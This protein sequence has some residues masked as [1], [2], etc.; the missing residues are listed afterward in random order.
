MKFS[1]EFLIKVRLKVKN[2]HRS[3]FSSLSNWKE[4]AWKKPRASTGFKPVTSAIPVRCSTNWT[5]VWSHTLGARSIYWVHISHEEWN[6]VKYIWNNS[7][8][9]YFTSFQWL[10]R[11]AKQRFVLFLLR[12]DLRE[13]PLANWVFCTLFLENKAQIKKTNYKMMLFMSTQVSPPKIR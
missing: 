7:F 8:H 12:K 1:K 4:E 13:I 9:I 11:L 5:T 3:K 10:R 2:D 6:D